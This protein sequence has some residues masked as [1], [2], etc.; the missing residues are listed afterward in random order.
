MKGLEHSELCQ[1]E[2]LCR[3]FGEYSKDYLQVVYYKTTDGE[4]LGCLLFQNRFPEISNI[5]Y[6]YVKPEFQKT[7]IAS[8]IMNLYQKVARPMTI[9]CI[10]MVSCA[11]SFFHKHQFK[12]MNRQDFLKYNMNIVCDDDDIVMMYKK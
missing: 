3:I 7:G 8:K 1:I 12:I 6:L 2:N 11:I 10:P 5:F 9:M 4:I